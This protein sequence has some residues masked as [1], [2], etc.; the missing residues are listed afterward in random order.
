M[1]KLEGLYTI[2]AKD[3]RMVSVKHRET[4]TFAAQR[5]DGEG[6]V[7]A[8][9][10]EDISIDK[11]SAPGATPY[12]RSW[13]SD[14]YF[15]DGARI[16]FM[17]VDVAR[18]KSARAVVERTYRAPE[19]FCSIVL[20]SPYFVKTLSVELRVPAELADGLHVM[21]Y[22]LPAGM[23]FSRKAQSDGSVVYRV[24][25]SDVDA[26]S[27]EP[28][29]PSASVSA[30]QLFVYGY[31]R[32][33]QELYSHLRSYCSPDDLGDEE[34]ARVAARL[35]AIAP[36]DDMAL[37][38]STL[39]WVHDNIWYLAVEHGEYG[40]RPA[41]AADVLARRAG[42]CKGSANLLRALLRR[43]GVDARL[44]WTGIN[45]YVATDWDSVP[46][47]CSGNH[48]IAAAMLGDSLVFLDGTAAGIPA[49]YVPQGLRG[50]RVMVEN[51]DEVLMATIP[52]AATDA[53]T[54][55]LRADYAVEGTDLRG[56]MERIAGGA[57]R[58][59]LHN[60]LTSVAP[61]ER[62]A[63]LERYL[64]YPK[65]NVAVSEVEIS[66][67]DHAACHN[68]AATVAEHGSAVRMGDRIMLDIRPIRSIYAEPVPTKGRKHDYMLS[69]MSG[70]VYRYRVRLPEGY[71]PQSLPPR[72]DVS[73]RWVEASIAYSY[74]DGVLECEASFKPAAAFV[75]LAELEARNAALRAVRRASENRI[76]IVP[77]K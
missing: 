64:R 65:K 50:R 48:M 77:T 13:E 72:F 10:N 9:Y 37:V 1:E 32:S 39:F 61:A 26:Y 31:F 28:Y 52:D 40:V 36:S 25:A 47:L 5:A 21:P 6:Y 14:D 3:G 56:R 4:T 74:A 8:M 46:A 67:P 71:E 53:D 22:R 15:Y 66:A 55:T 23:S 49:R 33:P 70:S 43:N 27:G 17:K 58:A 19:Q 51:G 57:A 60:I 73:D 11:A 63:M 30:P 29:A 20:V 2:S 18:G 12:Y 34:V 7:T 42:D 59:M 35:R 45:G 24:D 38:D 54:D 75:P 41:P 68:V 16:C 69:G 62:M 44:V 76:V